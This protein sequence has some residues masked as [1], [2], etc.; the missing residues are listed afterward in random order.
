MEQWNILNAETRPTPNPA[1]NLP[2]VNIGISVAAV[3]K[4]TPN[5]KTQDETIRAQRL[6]SRSAKGAAAKAPKKV[7]AE[8]IETI[9]DC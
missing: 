5:A 3:C 4:M 6:P 1:K 9:W 7:P 8:R 2:A